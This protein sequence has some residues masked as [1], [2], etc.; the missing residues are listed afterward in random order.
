MTRGSWTRMARERATATASQDAKPN[1]PADVLVVFGITGDLAR[2]MTF[3]SLYRLERRGV[4]DCPIVGVAV[5]D[6]TVDQLRSARAS[7]SSRRASRSTTCSSASPTGCPTSAATS[8]T[9][10][11]TNAWRGHRRAPQLP[12]FYLEIPPFLFG[13][14]IKGLAE[15]G[16][17]KTGS[18]RRRE[19]VRPRPAPQRA[20]WPTSSTTTSTSPSSTGST[21][22]SGS[23]ASRRYCSSASPTPCSSRSGTGTTSSACRSRWR[24]V[25]ASR[26]A[27]TSTTPSVLCAMSSP[28]TSCRWWRPPRWRRPSG[29]EP[30]TLK[31]AQADALPRRRDRQPCAVR[32]RSVRRLPRDRWGG[33]GLDDRDLRRPAARHRELALVGRPLLHPHGQAPAGHADRAAAGVQAAR[34]AS[35][36]R[37]ART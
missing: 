32:P 12:V 2:V 6:W 20:R 37:C 15:A 17:T 22:T 28:T 7:P 19:A 25:S 24:R 1:T 5:N 27:A 30:T 3:R 34:P 16:L 36:S 29:G 13:T 10:P 26:I 9:R 11:P 35:A 33:T 8:P 31:D 21:T 4:L 18:R 23:W 14:V